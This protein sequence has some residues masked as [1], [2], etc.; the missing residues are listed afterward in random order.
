LEGTLKIIWFQPLCHEQGH[1]PLDQVAQSSIQPGLEHCQGGGIHSFSGQPEV[2]SAASLAWSRGREAEWLFRSWAAFLFQ[3]WLWSWL[4]YI[5]FSNSSRLWSLWDE[6]QNK[7]RLG[8][9]SAL[10]F[11][12][13]FQ[14]VH[15]GTFNYLICLL[16]Q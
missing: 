2:S 6:K 12:H 5:F 15:F 10:C 8:H 7:C 4:L 16:F 1:L 9:F 3:R 14:R 11:K 13:F